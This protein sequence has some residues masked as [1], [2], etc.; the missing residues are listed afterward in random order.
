MGEDYI[1]LPKKTDEHVQIDNYFMHKLKVTSGFP[2][3]VIYHPKFFY[4]AI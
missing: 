1:P 3:K 2:G 4:K